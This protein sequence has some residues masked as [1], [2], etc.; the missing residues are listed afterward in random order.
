M[1]IDEF[2]RF[3]A[4][5]IDD[6]E[7]EKPTVFTTVPLTFDRVTS[8]RRSCRLLRVGDP[9][10]DAME[11][12]TRWDDRGC[13]YAFWRYVPSYRGEED[14]AVFFKFDFVVSPAIAPL[15]ALCERHPGASW[16]AVLRRTQTIMQSRFTT[17]WLDSDLERV[18]GKDDRA[19][20]LAPAF[21]KGRSG[22]K[23]DFNLNRNRWDAATELYD[24]SLWRDRCVAAREISERLLR[25]QSGLPKWSSECVEKAARQGNQIQQQFRSRL[26]WLNADD[27][28]YHFVCA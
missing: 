22:L 11:A 24:M 17:M 18:S 25:E 9:F 12:F 28:W 27:S 16:N 2:K 26:A 7:M 20:L 6:I 19:K 23:E 5:S 3:F 8:Q 4:S 21:S 13:S 1:P 15:K 10:V 14:P